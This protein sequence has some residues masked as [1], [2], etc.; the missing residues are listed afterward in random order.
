MCNSPASW[1]LH[2]FIIQFHTPSGSGVFLTSRSVWECNEYF[3]YMLP[4]SL[5]VLITQESSC[6]LPSKHNFYYYLQSIVTPYTFTLSSSQNL[7][8]ASQHPP[9]ESPSPTLFL[10]FINDLLNLTQCPIHS[11]ADLAFFN[12]IQQSPN[13]TRIKWFKLR[14]YRMPN[15]WSFTSFWLGQSKPGSVP[16]LE[17][18]ISTTIYST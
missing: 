13:P 5:S 4:G 3:G 17:N 2:S 15:I 6:S 11:Y 10:L 9:S 1:L 7:K 16:C 18:S 8:I 12:V 14:C